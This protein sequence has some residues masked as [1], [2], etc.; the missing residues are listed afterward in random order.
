MD[1][2]LVNA[3]T[4]IVDAFEELGVA[5][6]LG[7][8]V[9]SSIHGVARSSLDIDILAALEPN[10]VSDLVRRL[11]REYYVSANRVAD[12]IEREASFN[13]IH[14]ESMFKVDVFIARLNEFRRSSLQRRKLQ[15]LTAEREFFV[16]SPEDIVLHKL[17]WYRNGGEV[18]DR[19]WQDA[20]G[21]LKVQSTNLDLEY[22]EQWA[23]K[24]Q[25][26]DLLQRALS[27]ATSD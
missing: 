8:S 18:S 23:A 27:D 10:Q 22:L 14:L 21:V 26:A 11:E 17:H 3:L 9:A 4:P 16:T 5:Y 2:R 15:S 1:P 24:L 12:A 6:E 7:G 13:I 25:L 20:L 19:Q